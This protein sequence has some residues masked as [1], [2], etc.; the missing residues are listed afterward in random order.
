MKEKLSSFVASFGLPRL[1]ISAFLLALF[2][3]AP[4]VGVNLPMQIT[5]VINR[6]SWNAVLVLAMVPMVHSGCGLNFG[7]PV[8]IIAGLLGAT[9]SIEWGFT[10]PMSFVMAILIATPA[11]SLSS[12]SR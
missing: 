1:I 11:G 2:I 5:N 10:G 12:F 9:L 8:G 7:L 6:F 3:L 4:I